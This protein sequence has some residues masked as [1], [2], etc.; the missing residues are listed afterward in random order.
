MERY[1]LEAVQTPHSYEELRTIAHGR[2]LTPLIKY[3]S[4]DVHNRNVTSALL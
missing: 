1:F 4:E 2:S 3:L